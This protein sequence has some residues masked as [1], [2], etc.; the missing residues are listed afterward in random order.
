[1][2][3]HKGGIGAVLSGGHCN[4][5]RRN[6]GESARVLE[7]VEVLSLGILAS[8]AFA[9]VS[10]CWRNTKRGSRSGDVSP[11]FSIFNIMQ[12]IDYRRRTRRSRVAHGL[13][14]RL[15]YNLH[16]LYRGWTDGI[17]RAIVSMKAAASALGCGSPSTSASL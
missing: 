16:L 13:W 3:V 15:L 5:I 6:W 7:G 8:H 4:W 12:C 10:T 17:T 14:L 11:A 9:L 1:M 2:R